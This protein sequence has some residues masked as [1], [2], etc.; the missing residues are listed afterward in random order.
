VTTERVLVDTSAWITSFRRT[1][2]PEL[3]EF[4]KHCISSGSA[5][6]CPVVILELLQGCKTEAER[7]G[8]KTQLESLDVLPITQTTWERIYELGFSLGRGGLTLPTA[9]LII[10]AVALEH[11]A[12]VL[13]QDQHYEMIG[14]HANLRTKHFK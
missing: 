10:A 1:G 4:L 7:D 13:H 2:H 8:L 5:A 9:D 3:K 6:T 14:R 11:N 12:T